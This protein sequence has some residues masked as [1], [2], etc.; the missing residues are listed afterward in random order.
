MEL[1]PKVFRD[2]QFREK[3]RGGYHPEDVDEFLEQAAQAVDALHEQLRQAT[4]NAQRAQQAA[5]EASTTDDTL[6]RMLLI[7]QRTADQAV[8]EARQEA[9]H[10]LAESRSQAASMLAEAEERGRRAYES[11]LAEGRASMEKVDEALRQ[12]RHEVEVL[13]AWVDQH[14]DHLLSVLREAQ[15]LVEGAGF[16]TPP[17]VRAAAGPGAGGRPRR[18]R[19]RGPLRGCDRGRRRPCRP[20]RSC[21]PDG[22]SRPSG[23]E[24]GCDGGVGP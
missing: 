10:M 21:R 9:D 4:E 13:R 22:R 23:P 16:L 8:N 6:K 18:L 12:A 19:C 17:P 15:S 20:S 5:T 14:K 2:V 3:L 1:T 11:G 24:R 7:A